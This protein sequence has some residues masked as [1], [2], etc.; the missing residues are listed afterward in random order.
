M[1][2]LTGD[3]CLRLR[4]RFAL[5]RRPWPCRHGR[6]RHPVVRVG[7]CQ[8]ADHLEWP[9]DRAVRHTD[10]LVPAVAK[11]RDGRNRLE[12]GSAGAAIMGNANN[13]QYS[14]RPG[15]GHECVELR[16]WVRYEDRTRIVAYRW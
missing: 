15:A 13:C 9:G 3:P 12:D 7:A 16:A 4:R 8:L 11:C 14:R 6:L 1:V 5:V 10:R 2:R